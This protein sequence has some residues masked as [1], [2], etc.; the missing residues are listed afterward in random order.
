MLMSQLPRA[1]K[2]RYLPNG[3]RVLTPGDHVLCARSGQP[4]PLE[5]LRYWSVAAQ[6]PYA[7]AELSTEAFLG[8]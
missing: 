4:I 8:K 1:A 2:L 6:E 5:E 3:F 7:T